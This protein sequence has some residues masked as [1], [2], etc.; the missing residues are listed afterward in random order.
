MSENFPFNQDEN[1]NTYARKQVRRIFVEK[2][3][4]ILVVTVYTY[5]FKWEISP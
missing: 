1:G 4:Q 2:D 3:E 5:Y